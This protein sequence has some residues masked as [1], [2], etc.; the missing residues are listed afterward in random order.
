MLGYTLNNTQNGYKLVSRITFDNGYFKGYC[1]EGTNLAPVTQ[2]IF[3][4]F[5]LDTTLP[6]FRVLCG[7]ETIHYQKMKKQFWTILAFLENEKNG[8]DNFNVNTMILTLL[9][10][11]NQ[12]KLR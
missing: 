1:F 11:K 5:A 9:I 6:V 3:F 7:P 10:E 8:E 2:F 12:T 4:V